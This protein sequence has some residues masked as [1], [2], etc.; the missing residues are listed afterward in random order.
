M[1]PTSVNSTGRIGASVC[2]FSLVIFLCLLAACTSRGVA[3]VYNRGAASSYSEKAKKPGYYKV[4]SGDTLYS[5]AWRYRVDYHLLAGWNRIKGPKYRIYQGQ[6]LRLYP[7]STS[8]QTQ[9][10]KKRISTSPTEVKKVPPVVA[11][12]SQPTV[13]ISKT[14][15]PKEGGAGKLKLNWHWPTNGKVVQT[16]SAKDTAR[17]GIWITGSSGQPVV[18]AESG[19]VVYSGSGLVGYGNL[20]IIKHNNNYLSAYGYNKKLLVK[21]GDKVLKG[22]RIAQMGAPRNDADPVLHFE[23][24]KQGKP[25]DP[26]SLLPRK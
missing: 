22:E 14:I 21:E 15:K 9:H 19:K 12:K 5:I 4:K 13:P 8:R 11:V 20:I 1:N 18:A 24:R 10:T 23:I 3:P 26:L 17:K 7:P 6:W 16:Y 25:L 2:L